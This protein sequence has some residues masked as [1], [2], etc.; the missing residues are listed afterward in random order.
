MAHPLLRQG[1]LTYPIGRI[2]MSPYD[3]E[4]LTNAPPDFFEVEN[5]LTF[6]KALNFGLH[7]DRMVYAGLC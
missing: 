6:Q 1:R 7:Y 3:P 2:H 4:L 5:L